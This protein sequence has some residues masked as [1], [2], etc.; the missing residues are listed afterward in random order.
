MADTLHVILGATGH[1]GGVIAGRLLDQKRKVRVVGRD[2]KRLQPLAAR[3]AEAMAGSV[4]DPAFA[5]RALA[6]AGAAFLL[7]PPNLATKAFRAWQSKLVDT[8]GR[9]VESAKPAHVMTLSSIG[10]QLAQGNGPIAGL[11]ELEERLGSVKGVN[12]LN[13]RPGFFMENNLTSLGMVKQM[14]LLGSALRAD[15]PMPMIATQDIGEA[16]ARR[17]LALDF[18][19]KG[20]LELMGPRDVTMAEVARAIGKAIGK[21]DLP[22]VQFP[23]DEARKGMVGMGLPPEMADLYVEMSRGFNEGTVRATQPRSPA[24][25]TPTSI[26]QFAEKIFAPAY[27]AA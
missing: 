14:G 10:A 22:Y 24:T 27:R 6:G 15:L 17:M 4:D 20:V 13:L 9:A 25:T 11:H 7:L 26:E 8:L 19:G 2:A 3:G 5:A 16:G 23:Y 1:V 21:P 12:L 18:Q